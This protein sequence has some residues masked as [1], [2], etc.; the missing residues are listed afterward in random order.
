[1][2]FGSSPPHGGRRER[3]E[4]G[5]RSHTISNQ[6]WTTRPKLDE[7]APV[8]TKESSAAPRL[9]SV[10]YFNHGLRRVAHLK[11]KMMCERPPAAFG[12]S[13]PHGGGESLISPSVR[14]R[15][16]QSERGGRSHTISNQSLGNTPDIGR[17][18]PRSDER[19]FRRSAAE[20]PVQTSFMKSARGRNEPLP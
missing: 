18:G 17:M 6:S 4:R 15:L 7:W 16:E 12:G 8:V 14:G 19:I 11:F 1:M 10:R 2:K 13:P 5:G 9:I 20:N 3:S